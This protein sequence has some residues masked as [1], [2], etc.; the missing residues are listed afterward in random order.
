[1]NKFRT[2]KCN[3]LRKEKVGDKVTISGWI[4]KKRDHG[5]LL[6]ID[7]RDNYGITQCII[8]KEN[9]N[10]KILEKI[11]LETVIKIEGKVVERSKES[12]N[13]DIE[14]GEIEVI[15]KNFQVLGECKEL[16]LPVFSDRE[17][18][19]EIRL[20]YRF[21]DL[22]RKKIH[23]NII[24][25]SKVISFIRNE[26]NKLGFL[27]FQT[28]I[29]TSSSPEGARDFL[30]PSRLNPGKFYAL[31]QAPQQFK[32]LV[33]VSGFDK[34]FQIAPCFRDEDAR[35]DRSP[36]EFY[37]LDLE[38]SFVEQEDV[39]NVVE[40]LFINTFKKFSNKKLLFN[41]FPR[42]SFKESMI[43]YGTDKPDLRNPLIISDITEIFLR[44]DVSFEIFKKLVKS[45]SKVR[46]IVAKN[47]KDKPRSFFDNIDKWAKEQGA[48][49]LAYFTIEKE[50][51]ISAKGPVAKF[52]SKD[53]LNEIMI[54]T[55]A[56]VGDSIFLACGKLDEVEKITALA[57]DKIGKDLGL[58]DENVFAFCWIV[59]YPMYEIDNQ[60]NKIKFSHNPFSMPQG[61]IN[62]INFDKP[63]EILAYQYDIV[64]NGIELS[65]GAIR[66]H[67]PD[68]MYKLFT[69]AGYSKSD[70]DQ[71]FSGMIN[72]L[73]YGAPPHGGIAPGID[74]IIMLLANEKNIREVT[75]FPMNQNAQDLMMNAPSNVSE[76]QLKELN[77]SIKNKK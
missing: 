29:L 53:S 46:C 50:K 47:T 39:F 33:M 28:P 64:C 20:K 21:L 70:V 77:L 9:S 2:H 12:V 66:N 4:N 36:G 18:A 19:E 30:V 58:I 45:G 13:N 76:N 71:K 32:Q 69:V 15:I 57:R 74:R 5:N 41:Q 38:M 42:I 34:Y 27:E 73:S 24:L 51:E 14:T 37:Q 60:T 25:R 63:L 67:I 31:P 10:F 61:D 35:A 44:E 54:K 6:F 72:A 16:P 7:L 48:S 17:Y 8:D 62:K 75:M 65:S 1:M 3:E 68:L 26:M 23:E 43:K 55:K 11:Q 22:R 56:K 59:D 40:K 49:G 52:F